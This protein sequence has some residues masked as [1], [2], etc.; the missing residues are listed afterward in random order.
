MHIGFLAKKVPP[1]KHLTV[2]Q[3]VITNKKSKRKKFF[4]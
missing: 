1:E 2:F 4:K 3:F